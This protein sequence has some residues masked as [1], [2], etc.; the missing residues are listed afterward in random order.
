MYYLIK[1]GKCTAILY[2]SEKALHDA[3]GNI[4]QVVLKYFEIVLQLKR[5]AF[6]YLWLHLSYPDIILNHLE[7]IQSNIAVKL[8]WAISMPKG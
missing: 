6:L 3:S 8:A 4:I 7:L 2:P 5:F 1:R